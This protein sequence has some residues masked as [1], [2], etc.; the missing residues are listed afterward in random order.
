MAKST[1][2]HLP[3]PRRGL[4]R[5]NVGHLGGQ[6]GTEHSPTVHRKGGNQVESHQK[7]VHGKQFLEQASAGRIDEV[8]F[9]PGKHSAGQEEDD[10]GNDDVNGRPR[11]SDDELL[12]RI[13]RHSL[14]SRHAADREERNIRGPNAEAFGRE[15]MAEFMQ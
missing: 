8:E 6:Q 10:D 2:D 9:I 14:Q 11:D 5:G 4:S 3:H 1:G 12:L 7:E 13:G 15:G